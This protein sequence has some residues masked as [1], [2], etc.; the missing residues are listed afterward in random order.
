MD[1]VSNTRQLRPLES[2][3]RLQAWRQMEDW[4]RGARFRRAARNAAARMRVDVDEN[5]REYVVRADVPGVRKEDLK[6]R[7]DG[8]QVDISAAA[9]EEQV[10]E[11]GASAVHSERYMGNQ[12]RI[13][14]LAHEIDDAHA[15]AQYRHG[16]LEL[17]L[18]KRGSPS[19]SSVPIR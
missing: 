8:N 7:L 16:M 5:E 17:H 15:T 2:L 10:H 4:M 12:R 6:V 9:S 19:G 18:P 13:L 11:P 1:R 14:T 3:R